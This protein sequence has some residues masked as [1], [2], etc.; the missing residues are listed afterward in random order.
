MTGGTADITV[1]EKLGDNKI[2]EIYK[3]TGGPWGGSAVDHAFWQFLISIAGGPVMSRLQRRDTYDHLDLL[4]EFECVKRLLGSTDRDFTIK[5]PA[6][7]NEICKADMDQTFQELALESIH[8]DNISFVSD[9]MRLK[10]PLVEK[11]FQSVTDKI[12]SHIRDIL[13]NTDAGKKVGL[14]LMVGGFSESPFVQK[15]IRAGLPS[16][17][18][19]LIPKEAGL[20]VLNGAVVYGRVPESI[21]TRILRYTYGVRV[22]CKFR[23]GVDIESKR[24]PK[25][26]ETVLDAFAPFMKEGT[27]V[28]RGQKVAEIYHTSKPNQEEMNVE[29]FTASGDIPRYVTDRNC[30]L[31]GTLKVKIPDPSEKIR[32]LL[33]IYRFG[34]TTLTMVAIEKD[35]KKA[36][37]SAFGLNE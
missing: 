2:K 12:V 9:K 7:L 24:N 19:L 29:I 36:C 8:R 37:I 1:H 33:V 34:S 6:S 20:A 28:E 26:R 32:D 22:S 21:T 17:V 11:M 23:E 14:V 16:N 31:F 4:K 25:N 15:Q 27:P 18:K 13:K 3:A 30:R 35:S 5:L 10:I